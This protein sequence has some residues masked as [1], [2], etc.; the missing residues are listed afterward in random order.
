[1]GL[2]PNPGRLTARSAGQPRNRLNMRFSGE[3]E[4][5]GFKPSIRLTTPSGFRDCFKPAYLQVF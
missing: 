4:G 1:M 3:A 5:E 2:L